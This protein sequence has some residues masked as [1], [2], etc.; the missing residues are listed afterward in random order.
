VLEVRAIGARAVAATDAL[1]A[2]VRDRVARHL[3]VLTEG[4]LLSSPRGYVVDGSIDTLDV[5]DGP[6]GLKISCVVRLIVSA[7]GS[8]AMLAFATG[9]ATLKQPASGNAHRQAATAPPES[10]ERLAGE[11]L[12]GAVRASCDEL[13]QHFESRRKS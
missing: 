13:V 4:R 12:D 9:E 7:R 3:R 8:D 6:D 5:V 11:T 2:R 1:R 10:I